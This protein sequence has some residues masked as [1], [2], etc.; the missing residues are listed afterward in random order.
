VARLA[1]CA[2]AR[3]IG[4]EPALEADR[5]A[6]ALEP[7]IEAFLRQGERPEP[8]ASTLAMLAELADTLGDTYGNQ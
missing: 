3:S 7:A 1:A 8:R 6:V 2:E 4:F 5:R